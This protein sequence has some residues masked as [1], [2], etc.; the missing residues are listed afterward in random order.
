MRG[1]KKKDLTIN[2]PMRKQH[3]FIPNCKCRVRGH[4]KLKVKEKLTQFLIK[5]ESYVTDGNVG[6]FNKESSLV[7]KGQW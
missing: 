2:R 1:V 7:L 3:Y 4:A 6:P 5:A